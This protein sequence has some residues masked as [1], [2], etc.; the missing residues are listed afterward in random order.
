MHKISAIFI[1]RISSWERSCVWISYFVMKGFKKKFW[2]CSFDHI[3][4]GVKLLRLLTR[5][6]VALVALRRTTKSIFSLHLPIQPHEPLRM[7]DNSKLWDLLTESVFCCSIFDKFT[8][9]SHKGTLHQD[10][11]I[12][13]SKYSIWQLIQILSDCIQTMDPRCRQWQ[14]CQLCHNRRCQIVVIPSSVTRLG[15]FWK[16][17][18]SNFTAK[19]AQLFRYF[20]SYFEEGHV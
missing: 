17:L 16:F 1:G 12:R 7:T 14:L 15:D 8:R 11:A 18:V 3:Q 2:L 10:V 9:E 4:L 20:L 6:Q 19:V 13:Y 5:C